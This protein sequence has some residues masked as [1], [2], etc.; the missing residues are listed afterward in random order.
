MQKRFT[1]EQTHAIYEE[2]TSE[3][4]SLREVAARH[5]TD[6]Q[7][8]SKDFKRLGLELSKRKKGDPT[9][10]INPNFK[11]YLEPRQVRDLELLAGIDGY[12]RRS[13]YSRGSVASDF[14]RKIID[15]YI[16]SRMSSQLSSP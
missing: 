2:Y 5:N 1:D 16:A 10:A 15:D 7:L 3:G 4:L 12:Q 14:A 13:K 9:K 11:V 6:H 8:L